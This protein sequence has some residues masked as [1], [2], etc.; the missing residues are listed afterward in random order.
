M[1]AENND[2]HQQVC[3]PAAS[4]LA[5]ACEETLDSCRTECQPCP[6]AQAVAAAEAS[7]AQQRAHA[8]AVRDLQA[9]LSQA[10]LLVAAARQRAAAAER[11]SEALKQRLAE[12]RHRVR[13][14]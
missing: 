3:R 11:Q 13:A 10:E 9:Q 8:A 1:T 14:W 5:C 7:D 12:V 2:L 6:T 4:T